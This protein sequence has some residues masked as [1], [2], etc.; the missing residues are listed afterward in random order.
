MQPRGGGAV[1]GS[2][3]RTSLLGV[4]AYDGGARALGYAA[5]VSVGADGDGWNVPP[6]WAVRCGAVFAVPVLKSYDMRGVALGA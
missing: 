6:E 4:A 1:C 3:G 2:P 5:A